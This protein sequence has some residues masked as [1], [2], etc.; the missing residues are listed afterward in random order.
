MIKCSLLTYCSA[1]WS[2]TNLLKLM[3]LGLFM[4]LSF[5]AYSV[6]AEG[7]VYD[8]PSLGED[9]VSSFENR[10]SP[11]LQQLSPVAQYLKQ[12]THKQLTD[13]SAI[14]LAP[15]G[16]KL[17]TQFSENMSSELVTKGSDEISFTFKF[18]F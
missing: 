13:N 5:P 14:Y 8:L 4:L 16:I 10:N 3:P 1:R 17:E 18:S 9:S 2:G 7:D 6:F 11:H 15:K 12:L